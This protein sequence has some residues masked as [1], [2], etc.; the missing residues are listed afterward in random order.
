MRTSPLSTYLGDNRGS[1]RIQA[2]CTDITAFCCFFFPSLL[3]CILFLEPLV[4]QLLIP[5]WQLNPV[6]P[7]QLF[8]YPL[9][10]RAPSK[11]G[12]T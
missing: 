2:G 10:S 8:V 6:C 5:A 7:S 3:D 11:M 12:P 1:S 9:G 4:V